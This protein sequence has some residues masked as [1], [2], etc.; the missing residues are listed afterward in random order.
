MESKEKYPAGWAKKR[1]SHSHDIQLICYSS[2]LI[3]A[4]YGSTEN[5]DVYAGC[6]KCSGC[7]DVSFSAVDIDSTRVKK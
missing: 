7:Y 3:Q 1:K 5:P 4:I 2:Q 6:H